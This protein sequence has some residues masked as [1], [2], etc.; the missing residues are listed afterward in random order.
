MINNTDWTRKERRKG[1]HDAMII[2]DNNRKENHLESTD[3]SHFILTYTSR[4]QKRRNGTER[5]DAYC[6]SRINSLSSSIHNI[7]TFITRIPPAACYMIYDTKLPTPSFD[8][9]PT[10]PRKATTAY[11]KKKK[12]YRT[13]QWSARR[14]RT[15]CLRYHSKPP[16]PTLRGASLLRHVARLSVRFA[17]Y[18]SPLSLSSSSSS[19]STCLLTAA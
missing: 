8:W 16:T 6:M 5:H 1:A 17:F 3:N 13:S 2:T 14:P 18:T 7:F 11:L 10:H 19:Y 9:K 12:Q 15:F 4:N